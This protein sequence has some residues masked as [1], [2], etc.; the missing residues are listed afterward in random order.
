MTTLIRQ[1]RPP[2]L[3][4]AASDAPDYAKQA[5]DYFCDGTADQ[6]EI[7]AALARVG[8]NGKVVLTPGTFTLS[9]SVLMDAAGQ[10]LESNGGLLK[11]SS[12][13]TATDPILWVKQSDC[14]VINVEIE[15][16]GTKGNGIGMLLVRDPSVPSNGGVHDVNIYNPTIKSCDSGIEFGIHVAL[17]DSTGDCNVFGGDISSVKTGIKS[18]GFTNRV[19]GTRIANIDYGIDVTNDRSSAKIEAYGVTI[20]QWAV[21]AVR[22]RRGMGS[23]FENLWMEHTGGN[24]PTEA[25]IIGSHTTAGD[26]SNA[27]VADCHFVGTTKLHL[28]TETKGIVFRNSRNAVVENLTL[29]TNGVAPTSGVVHVESTCVGSNNRV[30]RMDLW[31][32][33]GGVQSAA[34][35]SNTAYPPPFVNNSATAGVLVVEEHFDADGT[36]AGSTIGGDVEPD[37]IATVTI[38]K[39][40]RNGKTTY[41]AKQPNG[42]IKTFS[43]DTAT[44]SGLKDVLESVAANDVHIHFSTGRF[45]FLDAP[46]G[47]ESWAGVEDHASFANIKRLVFSGEGMMGNTIVSNR[48]NWPTGTDTE[49][50]SFTNCQQVTIRD[51]QVESCGFFKST[52]DAIDFDAGSYCLVERVR[53]T[54]SRGRGIVFDGGDTGKYARGNRVVGCLIQGRPEPPTITLVSGGSLA[55]STEYRYCV[56][57]VDMDLNGAGTSGETKPSDPVKVV[58]TSNNRTARVFIPIGPYTTT[59]RK[60]YRWDATN[61][62]RLV[63]TINDNTTT[64]WD[65]NG[66]ATP[67]AATFTN[68]STIYM[69]GIELLGCSE[70]IVESNEIDGVGSDNGVN[71]YGINVVR[72][73]SGATTVTSDRNVVAKNI[74]R[75][76]YSRGI[77]VAGGSENVVDG[78]A[79]INVGVAAAKREG[80]RIEGLTDAPTNRNA[81]RNNLVTDTRDATHPT[82]GVGLSNAVSINATNTPTDNLIAYNV[83]NGTTATPISDAGTTTRGIGT[84]VGE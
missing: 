34:A 32:G 80:L 56:T 16:S 27:E 11:W 79:V 57:W 3:V 25:I 63:Q 65:D 81:M 33:S 1:Q 68:R 35:F 20:N 31:P 83:F 46:L 15:G 39:E 42:H 49:P 37:T 21:N 7:N 18:R 62:W 12:G 19:Y 71:Q 23:V 84:N 48:T 38:F 45:H 40:T 22:V 55:A 5:A 58:T 29:S 8:E 47:N 69:S 30:K 6:T 61:G 44:T 60:V 74:V 13:I 77:R 43:A 26:A 82:G 76:S 59:A 51:L 28:S 66:G 17:G 70:S 78:N 2:T 9:G 14:K 67:S 10:I 41:Y 24:A 52:T 50:F 54:R 73:G 53:V 36:T 75:G 64:I 72:K 4:V